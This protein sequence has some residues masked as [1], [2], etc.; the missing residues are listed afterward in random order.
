[1]S[2]VPVANLAQDQESLTNPGS[3]LLAESVC[4][5]DSNTAIEGWGRDRAFS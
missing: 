5:G 3:A 1:M 4:L 2:Q